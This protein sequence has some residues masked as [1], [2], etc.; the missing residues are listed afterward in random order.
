MK[1]RAEF[2]VSKRDG[3]CEWLRATKLARSIHVALEASGGGQQPVRALELATEIV[4]A[5]R[6][7][8]AT[9]VIETSK[10]STVVQEHLIERGYTLAALLYAE[11]GRRRRPSVFGDEERRSVPFWSDERLFGAQ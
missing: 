3:R 4:G 8:R 11:A 7:R 10:L 9:D 5:L 1:R 6:F 2:L